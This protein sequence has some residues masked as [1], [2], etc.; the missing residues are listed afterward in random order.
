MSRVQKKR[1]KKIGKSTESE[2]LEHRIAYMKVAL[3]QNK[4]WYT[5]SCVS[6]GT[7]G[8]NQKKF[9]VDKVCVSEEHAHTKRSIE[10][11]STKP[12]KRRHAN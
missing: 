5:V 2:E 6:H 11:N 1:L 8:E 4:H 7:V 12:R 3:V 9:Q 10:R